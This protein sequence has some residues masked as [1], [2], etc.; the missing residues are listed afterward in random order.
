MKIKEF[1]QTGT[2]KALNAPENSAT[3]NPVTEAPAIPN[4]NLKDAMKFL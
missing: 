1:L 3:P 2:C 4:K